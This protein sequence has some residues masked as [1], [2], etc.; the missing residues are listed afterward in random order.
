[1]LPNAIQ[2]YGKLSIAIHCYLALLVAIYYYTVLLV[3]TDSY[4]GV[5]VW[6][7]YRLLPVATGSYTSGS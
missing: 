2:G 4:L 3:A 1:M 6:C 7:S 5:A